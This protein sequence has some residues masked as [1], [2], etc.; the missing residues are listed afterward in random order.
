MM[1]TLYVKILS[2]LMLMIFPGTLFAADQAAAMGDQFAVEHAACI[3]IEDPE[4]R[5]G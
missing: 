5:L 4:T 1:R 3:K 2:Y